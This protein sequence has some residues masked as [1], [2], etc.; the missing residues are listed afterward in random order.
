MGRVDVVFER[1]ITDLA[2][3]LSKAVF[4]H[5]IRIVLSINHLISVL[6][7]L[8]RSFYLL[9]TSPVRLVLRRITERVLVVLHHVFDL[10]Q[11]LVI[12]G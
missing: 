8:L 10:F 3:V 9:M 2:R 4:L 1:V 6:V 12:V 11:I 7:F 5:H